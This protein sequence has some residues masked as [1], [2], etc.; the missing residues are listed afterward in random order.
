VSARHEPNW[1]RAVLH[2][3]RLCTADLVLIGLIR[4]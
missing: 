1:D 2:T 3:L 4:S